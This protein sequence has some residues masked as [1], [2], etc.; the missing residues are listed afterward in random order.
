MK[1]ENIDWSWLRGSVVFF[2]TAA[3][4]S[5][6]LSAGTGYFEK[7][8][9]EEYRHSNEQL[10]AISRRYLA[11]D[12]EEELIKKYLPVFIELHKT[13]LL[14]KEHRLNWVEVLQDAGEII[15]FPS[16][17]YEITAQRLY[18]P[19]FPVM[20][21]RYKIFA[22]EMTLDMQLLHEG[23]LFELLNLLNERGRGLYTVSGCELTRNF[24]ELTN[25]PEV[26]N[27]AA[28]C[29]LE[30]FSVKPTDESEIKV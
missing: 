19:A 24:V 10:R 15:Q 20:P 13:G 25:N 16:L 11:V 22:S 6:L 9:E 12:K 17:G 26:G 5:I 4:V 29:V 14:G 30:W 1:R 23:D 2:V 8:M 28:S 18:Q 27:V 7:H 3:A 21:G